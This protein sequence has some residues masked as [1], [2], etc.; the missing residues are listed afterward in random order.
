MKKL[1]LLILVLGLLLSGNANADFNWTKIGSSNAGTVFYIDVAT[2]KKVN[3]SG[4][5]NT[6]H[7]QLTDYAKPSP[8]GVLSSKS[9]IETNCVDYSYR[10][11]KDSYYQEPMGYGNSRS[12]NDPG[13][14]IKPEDNSSGFM[15]AEFVCNYK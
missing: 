6:L 1:F 2:I 13:R 10:T 7:Y 9:Y 4:W 14:W 15:L 12:Y 5:Y 11:L 8:A 3:N